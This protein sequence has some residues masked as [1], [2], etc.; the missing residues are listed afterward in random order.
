VKSLSE[1]DVRRFES[2][3]DGVVPV[4]FTAT[5]ADV[6]SNLVVGVFTT[7]SYVGQ[8]LLP[9][10]MLKVGWS[11]NISE[12]EPLLKKDDCGQVIEQT[13]S[14][15]S[16]I[17]TID[18]HSGEFYLDTLISVFDIVVRDRKGR[19]VPVKNLRPPIQIQVIGKKDSKQKVEKERT[20]NGFITYLPINNRQYASHSLKTNQ[21]RFNVWRAKVKSTQSA[22]TIVTLF[23]V[24]PPV[25]T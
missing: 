13:T 6:K 24:I 15:G 17:I 23:S 3:T 21:S 18:C 16:Y 7:K 9:A 10:G 11:V 25:T 1:C 5:D 8:I 12:G 22:R 4:G 20:K 19:E 2:P 14:P